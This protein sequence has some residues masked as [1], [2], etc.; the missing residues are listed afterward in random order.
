MSTILQ[1]LGLLWQR[2]LG[3]HLPPDDSRRWD[4][5]VEKDFWRRLAPVFDE[6]NNLHRR[7]P[8]I[9]DILLQLLGKEKRILEIGCG[10]GIYSLLMAAYAQEVIGV[11]LSPDMLTQLRLKMQMLKIDNITP[12]CAKW[13]DIDIDQYE[14]GKID[15]IVSINSLYRIQ[16]IVTALQ[17]MCQLSRRIIL[18]RTI[19]CPLLTDYYWRCGIE[20]DIC[21][22][23]LFFAPILQ[24]LGLN[25][26]VKSLTYQLPIQYESEEELKQVIT[27]EIGQHNASSVYHV[28]HNKFI[29]KERKIVLSVPRTT[30]FVY[31]KE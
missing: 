6:K 2:T 29:R 7:A 23:Y 31:T 30:V 13:E 8:M 3:W 26:E 5:E 28:L 11:D 4:D 12:L 25:V 22:D 19:Q 14:I 1:D 10:T 16:D 17:K 18:V 15:C 21:P 24:A 27:K 9:A 20:V